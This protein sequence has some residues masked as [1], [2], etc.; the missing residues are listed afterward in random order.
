M[1]FLSSGYIDLSKRRVSPEEAVKCEDK[2]TKSKTVSK[3]WPQDCT[4]FLIIDDQ[5]LCSTFL[6]SELSIYDNVSYYEYDIIVVDLLRCIVSLF[7]LS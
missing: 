3:V 2:Y 1:L 4:F 6:K 7:P 5:H